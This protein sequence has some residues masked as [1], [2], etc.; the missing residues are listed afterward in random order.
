MVRSIYYFDNKFIIYTFLELS[1]IKYKNR[2]KGLNK[3]FLIELLLSM[4]IDL[5]IYTYINVYFD[6]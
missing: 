2:K 3:L 5:N 1:I 6:L 4:I